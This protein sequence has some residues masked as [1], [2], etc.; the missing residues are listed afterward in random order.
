MQYVVVAILLI[1]AGLRYSDTSFLRYYFVWIVLRQTF[2]MLLSQ[3][4]KFP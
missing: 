3:R 1:V 4:V 2:C